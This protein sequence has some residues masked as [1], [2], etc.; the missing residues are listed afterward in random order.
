MA[1]N[2]TNTSKNKNQFVARQVSRKSGK[3]ASWINLTDEFS[4]NVFGSELSMVT[5][6]QAMEVLPKLYS[7]DY[8]KVAITDLTE[9]V[10]V[11]D[12]TEF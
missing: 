3:T 12:P 6:Q 11:V 10:K 2:S 5:A 4:R 1:F 7:N 8:L 9:E